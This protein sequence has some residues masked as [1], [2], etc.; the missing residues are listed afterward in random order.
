MTIEMFSRHET[1]L[2]GIAMVAF[3]IA[4]IGLYFLI[5]AVV[6][7]L[8][9]KHQRYIDERKIHRRY[10]VDRNEFA[11]LGNAAI[12]QQRML[13]F[14]AETNSGRTVEVTVDDILK[15]IKERKNG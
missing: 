11:E 5:E 13:S 12:R 3:V 1:M 6:R 4:V 15:E 9:T 14:I 10:E 2:F 8:D 7:F